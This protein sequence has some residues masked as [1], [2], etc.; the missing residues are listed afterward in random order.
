MRSLALIAALLPLPALGQSAGDVFDAFGYGDDAAAQAATDAMLQVIP[1]NMLCGI[2]MTDAACAAVHEEA[3][4]LIMADRPA[5]N[6]AINARIE[7][8]FN[9]PESR[10]AVLQIVAEAPERFAGPPCADLPTM[11][12]RCEFLAD[13]LFDRLIDIAP[14]AHAAA[15]ARVPNWTVDETETAPA[16]KQ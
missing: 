7:A 9:S 13:G 5:L 12:G 4:R 10:A 11:D 16:P 1:R 14:D 8:Q 3:A 6:D 2:A 15:K